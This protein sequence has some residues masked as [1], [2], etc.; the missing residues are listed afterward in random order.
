MTA[1]RSRRD[2]NYRRVGVILYGLDTPVCLSRSQGAT[3]FLCF[4]VSLKRALEDRAVTVR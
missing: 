1:P 3:L 2:S 4:S